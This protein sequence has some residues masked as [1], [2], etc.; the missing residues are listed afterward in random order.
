MKTKPILNAL[1]IT[2]LFAGVVLFV[3]CKTALKT[4]SSQISQ[5]L[6]KFNNAVDEGN[7][8]TL[9]ACFQNGN[10][11]KS[12]Q[13]LVKLLSGKKGRSGSK[14]LVTF[15]FD[16]AS[17][18]VKNTTNDL[19]IA[20]IPVTFTH[21]AFED[22]RSIL[23]LRIRQVSATQLKIVQADTRQF[24]P[25][26][27]AYEN[28]LRN[29]LEATKITYSAITQAAFKSANTLKAKYDSVVWFDHI[30]SKTFFY[31]VKGVFNQYRADS[32]NIKGYYPGYKM[33]LVNPDLKEIIPVEYDLIHN[34]NGT[35]PGLIEVEKDGKKG[36]YDLDGKNIVPVIYDQ[37]FPLNDSEN[38]ALFRNNDDYFYLKKDLTMTFKLTD[39]K[40]AEVLTKVK[41]YGDSYTLSEKVTSDVMEYSDKDRMT[42]IVLPPS[43][44]VDLK[45]LPRFIFFNNPLR[46]RKEE[47]DEEKG[48]KK[49]DVKYNGADNKESNWFASIFYSIIDNFWD[50]RAGLYE[51]DESK[52]VLLVDKKQNRILSYEAEN[53]LAEEE[54]ERPSRMSEACN[55]NQLKAIND[56]LFEYKTTMAVSQ[57][58]LN[59]DD[60]LKEAPYYY[61]LH[62]TD[63][64]LL[65][66]PNKRVFGCTKYVKMDD[67][68]LNGCFMVGN[69]K[70]DHMTT[71]ILQY[72]KNEIYASYGYKF[73]NDK[74]TKV[75]EY[76][77]DRYEGAKNVKVDDSLTTIEKYNINWINGKLSPQKTNT[78][79]AR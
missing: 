35:L 66:L 22:R 5:L 37:V 50:G 42:S 20:S 6:Y 63:G 2:M 61:Y 12:I 13:S 56:T 1:A 28:Y 16:V 38:L 30:N 4:N 78:L 62:I 7:A 57:S 33:G 65:A 21:V 19:A 14:P 71:S 44:L 54:E 8:D 10:K 9:M 58:L 67:S 76:R 53:F 39:F 68:Y 18:D 17:A 11:S 32:I 29:K 79:A 40:I 3:R 45:L 60:I 24:L 69:N 23:I 36:F 73:K 64:K 72:M 46:S 70:L 77:F 25:E 26:Y 75:F 51:D 59:A 41:N 55:E 52:K 43:Y 48:S 47:D 31:V 49:I 15:K 74:W 34:V 27:L